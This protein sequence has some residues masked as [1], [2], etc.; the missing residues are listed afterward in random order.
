M[1]HVLKI[2]VIL[3][4]GEYIPLLRSQSEALDV[5]PRRV[6][7]IIGMICDPSPEEECRPASPASPASPAT[8]TQRR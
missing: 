1:L 5:I 6:I 7:Q 4:N 8:G 3:E 2:A